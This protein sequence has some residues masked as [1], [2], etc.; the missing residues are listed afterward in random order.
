MAWYHWDAGVFPM[1]VVGGKGE[2]DVD[3]DDDDGVV[4]CPIPR[5]ESWDTPNSR[6]YYYYQPCDFPQR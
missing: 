2:D 1:G 4:D 6:L 5:I 3:D